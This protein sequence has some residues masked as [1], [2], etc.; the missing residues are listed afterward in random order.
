MILD[1]KTIDL[2]IYLNRPVYFDYPNHP[3]KHNPCRYMEVLSHAQALFAYFCSIF[4][5]L[6]L[7]YA[8][9]HFSELIS[10]IELSD[11]KFV[12]E[13]ILTFANE[14]L[15]DFSDTNYLFF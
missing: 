4:V 13:Q 12:I 9:E 8:M 10:T 11:E 7:N 1:D 14:L 3:S 5:R 2:D 6:Y 15:H